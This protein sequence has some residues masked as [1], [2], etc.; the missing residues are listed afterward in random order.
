M[1]LASL[2]MVKN[3]KTGLTYDP[4]FMFVYFCFCFLYKRISMWM[5]E[6]R[7]EEAKLVKYYS[8]P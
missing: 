3:F 6:G 1:L 4:S 2:V 5:E 8:N 7:L